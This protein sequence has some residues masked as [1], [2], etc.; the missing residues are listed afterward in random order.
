M[1]PYKMSSECSGCQ[2]V[3]EVELKP[4][5]VYEGEVISCPCST[6]IVRCICKEECKNYIQYHHLA[7]AVDIMQNENIFHK[8]DKSICWR[9]GDITIW[10]HYIK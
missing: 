8:D 9:K 10:R 1:K 3:C 5:V 6:C 4:S 7:T 2:R